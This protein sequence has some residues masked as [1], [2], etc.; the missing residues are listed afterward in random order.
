MW[1]ITKEVLGWEFGRQEGTIRLTL[2]KCKNVCTLLRKILKNKIKTL[3][4]FQK[5]AGKLQHAAFG[6]PGGWGLFTPIDMALKDEPDF[7]TMTPSLRQCLEDWRC[8]VQ[9][10]NKSSTSVLQLVVLPPTYIS[11]TDACKLGAGG[12]WCSGTLGLKPFLWQVEWPQDIRDMLITAE[13]P[14]GSITINDLELAGALLGFLVL[15]AQGVD[16]KYTHLATF[17]NNMTT[18]VWA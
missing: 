12:V 9:S 15:E 14:A 7:I 10:L 16:V 13:N 6:L 1:D 2:L 3:N 11:Y 8:I 18:V 5:L 17:C 4:E